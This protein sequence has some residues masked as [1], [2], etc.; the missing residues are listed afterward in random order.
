M[1]SEIFRFQDAAGLSPD[2]TPIAVNVSD[3]SAQ[4]FNLAGFNAQS[5]SRA[6]ASSSGSAVSRTAGGN[7]AESISTV[8][9]KTISLRV[10]DDLIQIK[11][12]FTSDGVSDLVQINRA[13]GVAQLFVNQSEPTG[14]AMTSGRS[15]T[16]ALPAVPPSWDFSGLADGDGNG[17]SDLY[18]TDKT[19]GQS[20]VWLSTGNATTPFSDRTAAAG[21]P[22]VTI[23]AIQSPSAGIQSR[24]QSIFGRI[25]GR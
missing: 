8:N 9:G 5:S 18:W 1:L 24:I 23:P 22:G 25:F 14:S 10:T 6:S 7:L 13:S 12:D 21:S 2:S 11:N 16:I 15:E 19:S 17:I 20:T 4:A 3:L